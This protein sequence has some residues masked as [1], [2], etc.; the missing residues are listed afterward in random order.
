MDFL[1]GFKLGRNRLR[2]KERKKM[3]LRIKKNGNDTLA[4]LELL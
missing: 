3:G 4:S 2:E 1:L